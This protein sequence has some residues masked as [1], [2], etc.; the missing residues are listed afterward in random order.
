VQIEAFVPAEI[1]LTI[2]YPLS[3]SF[4]VAPSQK[5]IGAF[6]SLQSAGDGV[7]STSAWAASASVRVWSNLFL[8]ASSTESYEPWDIFSE[9]FLIGGPNA[10]SDTT[11][12]T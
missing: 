8:T 9:V 5:P 12:K 10:G 1:T 7:F 3:W 6:L 11:F 2:F 4:F